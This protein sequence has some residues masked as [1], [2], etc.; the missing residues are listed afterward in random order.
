[1]TTPP[2]N[3]DGSTTEYDKLLQKSNFL[4]HFLKKSLQLKQKCLFLQWFSNMMTGKQSKFS[5]TLKICGCDFVK[6]FIRFFAL[7]REMK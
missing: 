2:R 7:C 6:N 1:L 3:S 5:H 4:Q